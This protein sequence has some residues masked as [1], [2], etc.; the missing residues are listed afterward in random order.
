MVHSCVSPKAIEAGQT[1]SAWTGVSEGAGV[2]DE[3]KVDIG[4]MEGESLGEI[5]AVKIEGDVGVGKPIAEGDSR[6]ESAVVFW[7]CACSGLNKLR[8]KKNKP[9]NTIER[10]SVPLSRLCR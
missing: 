3:A 2:S 6:E 4:V 10:V 9:R 7:A 1:A 8:P 5:V